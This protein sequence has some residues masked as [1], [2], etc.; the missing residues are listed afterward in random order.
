MNTSTEARAGRGMLLAVFLISAALLA[1][2]VLQTRLFSVMLWHHLTYMVVTITLLGFGAGGALYA[3]FPAIGRI[4]GHA[5]ISVALCCSLFSLTLIAAFSILGHDPTDTLDIEQ[6]RSRYFWL[7]VN[8]AYLIVPF[9]FAGLGVAIALQEYRGSVHKIYFWNLLGSGVGAFLFLLLVRTVGGPGCLFLFASL[10]GVAA[11]SAL[12][13]GLP[14]AAL[15][16]RVLAVLATAIWPL[17]LI[18]PGNAA[19]VVPIQPAASKALTSSRDLYELQAQLERQRDPTFPLPDPRFDRTI[20]SPLCRLDTLQPPQSRDAVEKDRDEPA[21]DP[22]VQVHVFQDGDAP[23]VIW[24]NSFARDYAYD[25]SFYGLGYRLVETPKV[26][27]I[28]PGG[29]NDVET[30][31]HYGAR[32]V[33][34]VDINGDTL[35]MVQDEVFSKLTDVYSRDK[36]TPVHSE[37]RSYLRRSGQKYDLIQMSGTDTYAALSSG[38]YIFSESYLYTVEAFEDYFDHIT[39][40]GVVSI[41]RFRFEPPRETLKLV[42]T[43]AEALRHRGITDP[44]RH[45]LVVNQENRGPVTYAALL[46]QLAAA[47]N[48]LAKEMAPRFERYYPEPLRYAVALMRLEPFTE[49]DVATIRA[50]LAPMAVP[51]VSHELYYAA[52][53]GDADSNEYH[54]L[55]TAAASGPE[56]LE[57]FVSDYAYHIEPA[58]DDKPFFFNFGSWSDVDPT[59]SG[60]G[61]YET[62]AGREPIG[63]YIL[64]AMGLQTILATALLVLVPLLRLRRHAPRGSSRLRVFTYFTALGLAFLLVEISS[65]QRYVLY[66]GHPTYSLSI[67][68]ASFL[69]FSGLGSAT[70][71]A[72]RLGRVGAAI[73]AALVVLGLIASAYLLPDLLVSTLAYDETSRVLI[74]IATIAPLAFF[75]GMP[76]P[77]G[78]RLL[79]G[80]ARG[81]IAWAFGINGSASVVASILAIVLAMEFGFSLVAVVAA[82]LYLLAA[83]TVPQPTAAALDAADDAVDAT[84][85]AARGE[86]VGAV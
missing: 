58:T 13:G 52:G 2:Q 33:T 70:A 10:G 34:A 38:S 79:A 41:I 32:E 60:A 57:K 25:Q 6:D 24:S 9:L 11:L 14:R 15:P 56:A 17:A 27:V 80:E 49:Q 63:L 55:L 22:R 29:G 50:A 85:E 12:T 66:L 19:G 84:A 44:R 30:A 18:F 74:A 83:L 21:A 43:A 7:F 20:W 64:L 82:A 53:F 4:G 81:V 72:L 78:L 23:T 76:F 1:V 5:R 65:L 67:G 51:D 26:L 69:V 46:G 48:Q 36:V 3:V 73:A 77:T 37:G 75:M 47:G 28:G 31:L 62:I 61:D 59:S 54:G 35:A 86:P 39:D 71:G 40:D 42:A 68:L 45:F 8:Y 16:A